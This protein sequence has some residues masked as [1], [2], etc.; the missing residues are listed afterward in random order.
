MYAYRKYYFA[1][2]LTDGFIQCPPDTLSNADDKDIEA[3]AHDTPRYCDEFRVQQ[4]SR[5]NVSV[6]NKGFQL[7]RSQQRPPTIIIETLDEI[8]RASLS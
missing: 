6:D 8:A 1:G 7:M 5:D 2:I 4:R 3:T